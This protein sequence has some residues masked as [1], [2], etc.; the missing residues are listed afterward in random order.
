MQLFS[1][2]FIVTNSWLGV[3]G[4]FSTGLTVGG[5]AT[6]IYGLIIVAIFNVAI[7]VSLGELVS[8]MPNAGGQ[9]YWAMKLA[10]QRLSRVSAYIC[11]ICNLLG[12]LT[13]TSS[14]AVASAYIEIQ[15][16][17]VVLLSIA[18]IL[19]TCGFNFNESVITKTVVIGL[20][21][22]L[23]ACFAITIV[24]AAVSKE[25]SGP[26]FIFNSTE[27][28]SGWSSPGMAFLV[29][30]INANYAFGLIDSGVHMAE[31]IPSPEK[32]VPKALLMAVVIGFV[33]AWPLACALIDCAVDIERIT[34]TSTGL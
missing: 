20:W 18:M 3:A 9:Y 31:E 6:V 11:G 30:M 16:W 14:G 23:T 33:T 5:S 34:A 19:A 2:A 13:G 10:P 22:C 29:G 8:S 28:S 26:D 25:H 4:G 32:N 7:V 27:N 17:H 1:C 21:F 24:P 15:A 12:G